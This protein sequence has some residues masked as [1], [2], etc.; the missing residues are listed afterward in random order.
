MSLGGYLRH[1]N[2]ATQTLIKLVQRAVNYARENGV[3]PLGSLGNAS[4]DLSD[5]ELFRDFLVVPA[6]IDGVI[7][8]SATGYFNLKAS[9]SNYGVGKTDISTPVSET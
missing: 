6:E 1:A 3:T 9:Y 7:G 8:V 2:P 4:L 5:G